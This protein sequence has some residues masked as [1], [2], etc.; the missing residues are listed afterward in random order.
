MNLSAAINDFLGFLEKDKK[1]SFYTLKN[2]HRYL[3][4]FEMFAGKINPAEINLNLINRYKHHLLTKNLKISTQNYFLIALRSFLTYLLQRNLTILDPKVISLGRQARAGFETL[5]AD[6]LQ[7]ALSLAQHSRLHPKGVIEGLRD[8]AILEVLC[9][10][11]FKVSKLAA[12]N[13]D[14]IY[15]THLPEQTL[16]LLERYLQARKDFFK[17]LFIRFQGLQDLSEDGEKK[18]LTVRSL[19]RIVKKYTRATPQI[20]RHSYAK[21]LLE[22]GEP[23]LEVQTKLG[24][25]HLASTKIYTKLT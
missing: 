16:A 19:E 22:K 4:K 15:T 8:R 2:Y 21:A 3:K 17:P 18:R 23:L 5:S 20:L 14:G 25:K 1:A 11:G 9:A 24:H 13:R 6:D 10:T 12:L 7:K